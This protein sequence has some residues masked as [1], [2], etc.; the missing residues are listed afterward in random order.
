MLLLDF[1]GRPNINVYNFKGN[2]KLV[3]SQE[4]EEWPLQCQGHI[5]VFRKILDL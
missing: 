3:V 1:K 2:Y 5:L 4:P